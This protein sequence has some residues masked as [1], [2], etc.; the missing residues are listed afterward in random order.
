MRPIWLLPLLAAC[1]SPGP[2]GQPVPAP[3]PYTAEQIR[4]ANPQGT[5]RRYRL[6]QSGLI[7]GEEF[8]QGERGGTSYRVTRSGLAA[9]RTWMSMPAAEIESAMS[10]PGSVDLD[11]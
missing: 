8:R 10:P 7:R 3:T 5:L 2:P 4:A 1:S 6:E 11:L 9:L